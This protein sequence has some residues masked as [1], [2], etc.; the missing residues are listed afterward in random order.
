MANR[1]TPL[2]LKTERILQDRNFSPNPEDSR[3]ESF[4]IAQTFPKAEH[5]RVLADFPEHVIMSRWG[6][7]IPT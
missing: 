7:V 6:S 1:E 3:R 4:C 5:E 2:V